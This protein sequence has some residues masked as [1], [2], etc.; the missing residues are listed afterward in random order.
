MKEMKASRGKRSEAFWPSP[1]MKKWL[2]VK[3]KVND[4]SEDEV[5]TETESEDG[6]FYYVILLVL[7]FIVFFPFLFILS[8]LIQLPLLNIQ[9]CASMMIIHLEHKR[10][11]PCSQVKHQ[12]SNCD[13]ECCW[14]TST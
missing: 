9:E 4:F 10:F 3:P 2:N 12:S 1:V 5:D 7:T 11:N 13:L 14:K 6:G 8:I